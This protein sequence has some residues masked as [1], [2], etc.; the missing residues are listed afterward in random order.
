MNGTNKDT[1]FT[2]SLDPSSGVPFY[3]QIIQQIEHAI[4]S[5]RL[6]CGSRLPTIRSLAITLKI[7]PN[8]IAKAYSELEIRGIVVTQVGS[9]TYVSDKKPDGENEKRTERIREVTMRFLK[10]MAD[11]GV[12]RHEICELLRTFKEEL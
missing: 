8:T 3:R 10:D 6:S 7:N 2:I 5:G 1:L 12:D 11:L 4:L 9:G